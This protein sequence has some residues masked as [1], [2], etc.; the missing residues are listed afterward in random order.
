MGK[1]MKNSIDEGIRQ[2]IRTY[3]KACN[4]SLEELA[5]KIVNS[6]VTLWKYERG[7]TSLD[8]HTLDKMASAFNVKLSH[9]V[10][11]AKSVLSAN[12]STCTNKNTDG[13]KTSYMYFYDGWEKTL[14]RSVLWL[15]PK[16]E[17]ESSH[18]VSLFHMV[19]HS[20]EPASGK[21]LYVGTANFIDS[22]INFS[23]ANTNNII[24]NMYIIAQKPFIID[25]TLDG[26]V[27]GISHINRAPI[28]TRILIS[29]NII[30]DDKLLLE[31]LKL[32]KDEL[33]YIKLNNALS[34]SN[35]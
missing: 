8:V 22:Y 33:S 34:I 7:D 14:S 19:N 23:L 28:C 18:D 12:E 4:L 20:C 26:I 16:I 11:M 15:S 32:H 25:G 27:L 1:Y 2:C 30:S 5:S 24:E 3:R 6:R 31:R 9:M 10:E 13:K 29:D 35:H 17:S 21:V